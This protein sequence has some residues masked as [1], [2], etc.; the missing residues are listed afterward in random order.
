[1]FFLSFLGIPG[2]IL[3]SD[4]FNHVQPNYLLLPKPKVRGSIHNQKV[5]QSQ[6]SK[7]RNLT[8][9]FS[10]CRFRAGFRHA[11]AWC[12]FIKVSEEDKM[13]LQHTH[14]FRVTMTRSHRKDSSYAHTSIKTNHTT[15]DANVAE[16]MELSTKRKGTPKTHGGHNTHAVNRPDD[17]KSSAAKLMQ[18]GH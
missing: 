7:P 17:T 2:H 3:V 10:T 8:G 11:F 6:N 1:M 16:S 9:L 13:E 18:H 5:S 12:P 14:T 15:I 4:E